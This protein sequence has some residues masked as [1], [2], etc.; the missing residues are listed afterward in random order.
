MSRADRAASPTL[1][2]GQLKGY[3]PISTQL[4][5]TAADPYPEHRPRNHPEGPNLWG[6]MVRRNRKSGHRNFAKL[7]GSVGTDTGLGPLEADPDREF[8]NS[9]DPEHD[10][11]GPDW[12][13]DPPD[14]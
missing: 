4:T 11:T 9:G 6:R 7:D 12:W 14:K 5:T 1:L 13:S 2:P 3:W 10:Q 8:E